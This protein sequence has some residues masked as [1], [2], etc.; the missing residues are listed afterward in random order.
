M[1]IASD[2][3][4]IFQLKSHPWN[5]LVVSSEWFGAM[6]IRII[7]KYSLFSMGSQGATKSFPAT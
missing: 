1:D 2:I 4:P 5:Y 3:S 6:A 7:Q